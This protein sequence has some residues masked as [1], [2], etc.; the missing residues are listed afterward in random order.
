MIVVVHKQNIV[1]FARGRRGLNLETFLFEANNDAADEAVATSNYYRYGLQCIL[2]NV[3][4][5]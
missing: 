4:H 2:S 1:T 5:V 3:L